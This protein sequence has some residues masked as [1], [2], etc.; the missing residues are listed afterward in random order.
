MSENTSDE[1]DLA[2]LITDWVDWAA[3]GKL[4]GVSASRIRALVKEHQ[5]ASAVPVPGEGVKL[6]AELFM[7]GEIVKGVSGLITLLHDGRYDDREILAWMFTPDDSLP[8][9]PIDALRENRGSEVK[10]RAH[11]MAL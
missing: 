9:R 3:A 10:R 8:G 6:P 4:I 11:A 7:D 2:A 5:L 1:V